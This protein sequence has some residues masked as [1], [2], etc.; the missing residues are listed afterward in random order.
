MNKINIRTV[1]NRILDRYF[2]IGQTD[3]NN[4]IAQLNQDI[5]LILPMTIYWC[6]Q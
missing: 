4:N 1:F 3:I 5:Y 6:K 2:D